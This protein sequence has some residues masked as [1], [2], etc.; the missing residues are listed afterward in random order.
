MLHAGM[1]ISTIGI[2][3]ILTLYVFNYS[4]WVASVGLT[5]L[6]SIISGCN[7]ALGGIQNAARQRKTVAMHVAL[8]SVL[9][10]G[11]VL[12]LCELNCAFIESVLLVYV[13]AALVTTISQI[14]FIKRI[15]INNAAKTDKGYW[16]KEIWMY[17]VP[18]AT[19]GPFTWLQQISDRWAL[20]L[21]SS[22]GKVGQYAVV[23]QIG[24]TPIALA[25]GMAVNLIG[26][27]LFQRSGDG[28]D[29]NRNKEV[30]EMSWNLTYLALTFT[31]AGFLLT[32]M[33][34]ESIFSILVHADYRQNSY[35][36]PWLVLAGG[37]YAAG[38]TL[39]LKIMSEMRVSSMLYVKIITAIIGVVLNIA[40]ASLFGVDGVVVGMVIF[41]GIFLIWMLLLS[42]DNKYKERVN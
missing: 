5:V 28:K 36:L 32:L 15:S 17:A 18:F 40:G 29:K 33:L 21:F 37:I 42:R 12:V 20:E 10:L 19:W 14:Y 34:H 23:Y 6:F 13:I 24:F 31:C 22:E 2:L 35:L 41:S 16:E 30:N 8:E 27:I 3:L 1:I 4:Q 7:T 26:P 39:S 25:T 11:L 9:K 38:Q